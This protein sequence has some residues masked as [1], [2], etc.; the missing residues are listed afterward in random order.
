MILS[1]NIYIVIYIFLKQIS[2]RIL[3]KKH[4]DTGGQTDKLL[5]RELLR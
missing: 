2:L 5:F 3:Q 4:T 1:E